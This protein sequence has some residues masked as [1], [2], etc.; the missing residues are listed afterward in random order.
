LWSGLIFIPALASLLPNGVYP[1]QQS[2]ETYDEQRNGDAN[3]GKNGVH[4]RDAGESGS[5]LD[6][7]VR[8]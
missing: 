5:D 7:S 8:V 1:Q 2:E 3:G 6:Y 4:Q